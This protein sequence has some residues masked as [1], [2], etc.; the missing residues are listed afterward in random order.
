MS[1]SVPHPSSPLARPPHAVVPRP[2]LTRVR[3]CLITGTA[4]G[5]A[6]HLGVP[7]W[8]VRAMFLALTVLSG[9]GALLYVWCWVLTPWE[10]GKSAP[11]R[12][13]PVA[14]VLLVVGALLEL[15]TL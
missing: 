12:R 10:P 1:S 14:W 7:V 5:L 4:A 8:L 9:A 11:S 6:R 13:A 3:G 2:E 15:I